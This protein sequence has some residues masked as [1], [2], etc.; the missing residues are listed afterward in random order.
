MRSDRIDGAYVMGVD[1]NPL[2]ATHEFNFPGWDWGI[3]ANP[4]NDQVTIESILDQLEIFSNQF[5]IKYI[6]SDL[7]ITVWLVSPS[8]GGGYDVACK[9]MN[10]DSSCR[11]GNLD[12]L[13]GELVAEYNEVMSSM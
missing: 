5:L 10:Y 3:F 12:N 9:A 4:E 2:G 8:L 6:G 13:V 1:T 7:I 11:R